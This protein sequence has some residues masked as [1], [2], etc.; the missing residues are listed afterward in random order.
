MSL[1]NSLKNTSLDI[2]NKNPLGGPNRSNA[3]NVPGGTYTNN[4]SGNKYGNSP[5]GP[6]KDLKGEIINNNLNSYGPKNTYLDSFSTP[7]PLPPTPTSSPLPVEGPAANL[8]NQVPSID[9]GVTNLI[10]SQL[11]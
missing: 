2:E 11:K 8:I 3:H 4:R 9:G 6:L 10:K 7:T 1:K 5:G